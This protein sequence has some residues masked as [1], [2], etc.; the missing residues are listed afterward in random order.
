MK[1]YARLAGLRFLALLAFSAAAA[2]AATYVGAATCGKC[3]ADLYRK[4]SDS[5]HNKMI[6]PA[7]ATS[8]KGDFSRGEIKLRGDNYTLRVHAGV[9]YIT[10]SYL[11]GKP[12]ERRV[13]YTL[14]SRR[15][16]HYLTTIADGRIIV[17]PPSWDVS[18]T[19]WFHNFD[20]G[21]P[22]ESGHVEAQLW[23]KQC[24]SCHVSQERKNFNPETI[25][26]KTAWIDFGTNCERCHR[27]G[28]DHVARYSAAHPEQA[29]PDGLVVQTRL[30]PVRNTMVCAQC[31]SFR[32]IFV[33]G[34]AAGAN[35][36]DYFM[37]ILEYD[38]P[39]DR[40]P[41]Y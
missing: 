17:L 5:R 19:Q 37:P 28:S 12:I 33:P 10:E 38:Q 3:H 16:Q 40:D 15:I 2:P 7:N 18:R 8:V 31:H 32:D 6:Q 39:L 41:A 1:P 25:E 22:D 24:F 9:Y 4:W 26:Y 14:G 23:N 30:D 36:Y 11:T 35:Y 21:D 27:P 13:D 29:A 34:Y 20:I